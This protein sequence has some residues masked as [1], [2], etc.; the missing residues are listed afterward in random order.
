MGLPNNG[1]TF[2]LEFSIDNLL[3]TNRN[4]LK[5]LHN[6][7]SYNLGQKLAKKKEKDDRTLIRMENFNLD[8]DYLSKL[9]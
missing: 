4:S 8:N 2:K 5:Y 9:N 3:T 6:S 7:I 1:F